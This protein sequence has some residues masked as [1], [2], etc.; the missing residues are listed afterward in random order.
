MAE[1]VNTSRVWTFLAC[2][3]AASW[4]F[5]AVL[6]FTGV[7]YAGGAA[8][9]IAIAYMLVP[10]VMTIALCRKWRLPLRE[11]GLVAHFRAEFLLAPILPLVLMAATIAI[12]G[13]FGFAELQSPAPALV[14]QLLDSLS[15]E[16]AESAAQT[17]QAL[18]GTQTLVLL[19][20]VVAALIS[21][22][23]INAFFALS[24]ELGWRGLL[25]RE[26]APL[27]FAR[28]SILIGAIWGVWHAPLIL[29]GHNYPDHP[30]IG[31]GMMIA[32]CIPL[33]VIHSWV[34]LKTRTLLAAAIMH[35][36]LNAVAGFAALSL[37][38]GS[39]LTVGLTGVS[40]IIVVSVVAVIMLLTPPGNHD[41]M[42]TV[43]E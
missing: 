5:A 2:T 40:G 25:Q 6:Y 33:G 9:A 28:S 42:H 14:Q 26:L 32:W 31:V 4:G 12:A 36:T 43:P 38:G 22:A 37:R 29:Q 34:R 27:G 11:I 20:V 19:A 13:A 41:E 15:P 23:S 24:E 17:L 8:A 1:R 21:G 3:F 30:I 18:L 39:D 10:G 16:Q 7:K 35:G